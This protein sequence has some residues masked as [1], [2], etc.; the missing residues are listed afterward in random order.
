M[1]LDFNVQ[2]PIALRVG[3]EGAN[4][5]DTD[6]LGYT[7]N[8]DLFSVQMQRT[9]NIAQS[10]DQGEEPGDIIHTGSTVVVSGVLA[11]WN[12]VY[13]EVLQYLMRAPGSTAEGQAGRIGQR[14]IKGF[15]AGTTNCF[16]AELRPASNQVGAYW[17]NFPRCYGDE[18]MFSIREHGNV[19]K[20]L[21]F[22][23]IAIRKGA[24]V[25]VISDGLTGTDPVYRK[26]QA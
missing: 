23:F 17:Y 2:G 16:Q 10:T 11:K 14:W 20:L 24:A 5:N 15:P 26:G 6:I 8:S 18:N 3:I 21:A 13:S 19:P 12:A 4:L 22:T 25:G 9:S 7:T 1:A